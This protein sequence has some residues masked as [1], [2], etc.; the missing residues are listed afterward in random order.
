MSC[1]VFLCGLFLLQKFNQNI[2]QSFGFC[3]QVVE[4][5][6]TISHCFADTFGMNS[7]SSLRQYLL[8]K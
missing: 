8:C 6:K 3:E 7:M 2:N 4:Q 1:F 5:L